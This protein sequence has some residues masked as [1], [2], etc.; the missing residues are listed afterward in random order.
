[1]GLAVLALAS[2]LGVGQ[3][4]AASSPPFV[5]N[6]DGTVSDSSTG[7]MWDQCTDG[8]SG[9]DCT[10]GTAAIYTWANALGPAATQNAANYKGYS[11][12]RLSNIN[13]LRSLIV[14]ANSPKTDTLAFPGT[15]TTYFFWTA[16]SD[17]SN[18][19]N[20]WV[21]NFFWPNPTAVVK[22]AP[23]MCASCEAD[24]TLALLVCCRQVLQV[25]R[26]AP[27]R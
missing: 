9:A 20:A 22:L 6:N 8:L 24:S 26:Q 1:M 14:T 16:S 11:D 4:L 17:V 21:D 2:L 25:S 7:L 12:W 18:P 3:A 27:L 19:S 15:P 10:T 13:E 23:S 5:D